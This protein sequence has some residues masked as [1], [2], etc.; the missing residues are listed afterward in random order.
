MLNNEQETLKVVAFDDEG[1]PVTEKEI[2]TAGKL[3]VL[4]YQQT[5]I[6]LLP[7]KKT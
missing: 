6:L 4:N 5:R 2:H 3:T 7:I 1:K